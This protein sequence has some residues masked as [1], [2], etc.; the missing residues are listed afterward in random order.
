MFGSA[1]DEESVEKA[2]MATLPAIITPQDSLSDNLVV[3]M[4]GSGAPSPYSED[5]VICD[6]MHRLQDEG[7][8]HNSHDN[9][10][11][12]SSAGRFDERRS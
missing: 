1:D 7:A 5:I 9:H 8:R 11:R 3:A 4:V 2:L 12:G 10:H 6:L